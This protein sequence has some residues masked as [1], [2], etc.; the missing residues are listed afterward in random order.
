M[1]LLSKV[2][3]IPILH[4][5]FSGDLNKI[6][7][8]IQ[9]LMCVYIHTHTQASWPPRGEVNNANY[10]LIVTPVSRCD[11]LWSNWTFPQIWRLIKPWKQLIPTVFLRFWVSYNPFVCIKA[12][13]EHTMVPN[14]R[15]SWTV[16]HCRK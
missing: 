14:P 7:P 11:I 9:I 12:V 15:I 6:S 10:P 5:V 1:L 13:L 3:S 2:I 4:Y 16:L 8:R